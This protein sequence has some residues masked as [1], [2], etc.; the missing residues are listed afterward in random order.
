MP[1][2]YF[3]LYPS[4]YGVQ[5]PPKFN[6][7]ILLV[8]LAFDV[9]VLQFVPSSAIEHSSFR[10]LYSKCRFDI[11]C[12]TIQHSSLRNSTFK[13]TQFNIQ[14]YAIQH[15]SFHNSTFKFMQF[16]I[17]VYTIQHSS[18]HNSTFKFMQFNIQVYTIQHSSSR[19]STFMF[20]Q[21]NTQV[22]AIWHSSLR[23]STF[24]FSQLRNST[25]N[26]RRCMF[27]ISNRK[28]VNDSQCGLSKL[29]KF[30]LSRG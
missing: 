12:F 13:F 9:V 8:F 26:F 23:N 28:A 1:K 27:S 10:F 19:N 14:V 16:N 3:K 22:N 25:S 20:T 18:F 17:Q 30:R 6:F 11:V 5:F 7:W 24:K 21:F 2:G 4:K 29:S 15:S